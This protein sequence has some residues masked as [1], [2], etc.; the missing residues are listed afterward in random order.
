M[1][2]A[3]RTR[4]WPYV[5]LLVISTVPYLNTL[6][7]GFVFDDLVEIVAPGQKA[8]TAWR[9]F[10][11]QPW[12][13]P[14]FRPVQSI[15]YAI[16]FAIGGT[17]PRVYH[18]SNIIYHT[19]TVLLVFRLVHILTGVWRAALL[20]ALLFATHPIQTEAVAYLMGRRD[21]LSTLFYLLGILSFIRYRESRSRWLL[22]AAAAAYLLAVVSKEI[23]VT[24]PL[25]CLGYDL[26]RRV[27]PQ[28]NEPIRALLRRLGGS[29]THVLRESALFYLIG[30]GVAVVVGART[31]VA[32][33]SYFQWRLHDP[34]IQEIRLLNAARGVVH[35]IKL[36][37]FPATLS[38]DYSYN[39]FP[40]T[41]SWG[42]LGGW[43][44]LLTLGLIFFGV[45]T[46]ATYSKV[47][48]FGGLW[49]FITLLPVSQ[50]I[51][52]HGKMAEH[53]LYLPVVGVALMVGTILDRWAKTP[54]AIQRLTV[55]LS[56]L[57]LFFVVRTIVRN[58]DWKDELTLWRKTVL[59]APACGRAHYNLGTVLIE[60]GDIAGAQRELEVALRLVN[61]G[62]LGAVHNQLG[63]IAKKGGRYDEAKREYEIALKLAPD[64]M[65]AW[66]NLAG[67]AILNDQL[68][69]ARSIME[70]ALRIKPR[71]PTAHYRLGVIYEKQGELANAG[72]EFELATRNDPASAKAHRRLGIV[73]ARQG[74]L[75]AA[76]RAFETVVR[77]LPNSADDH[78]NLALLYQQ[79]GWTV[80]ARREYEIAIRLRPALAQHGRSERAENQEVND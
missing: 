5:V 72:H 45:L 62:L 6:E 32:F 65:V 50:I 31:Y 37:L 8:T 64:L 13:R 70:Q 49:F 75:A 12:G 3:R 15:S 24:F 43:L 29:L 39:A 14:S 23:A 63:Y 41:D 2:P 55:G 42:D 80:G 78:Y 35:Y 79:Q 54:R 21:L 73:T 16:D 44:A 59:T 7:N 66:V 25:V 74:D 53:Y 33:T 40:V 27:E 18:L 67:I 47:A 76:I 10:M 17:N 26:L 38:A 77:L 4:V 22:G 19:I 30:F 1:A 48:A 71:D 56:A 69:V 60:L 46:L 61:P 20:A 34:G 51:P 52:L 57:L 36:L 68:D 9:F 58:R 11:D 28:P